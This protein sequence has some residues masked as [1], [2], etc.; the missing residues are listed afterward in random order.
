M[1]ACGRQGRKTSHR[2][3]RFKDDDI[4]DRQVLKN[5]LGRKAGVLRGSTVGQSVGLLSVRII[6][7]FLDM[8]I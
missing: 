2:F 1:P 3:F 6:F 8:S 7:Y 5:E 4:S